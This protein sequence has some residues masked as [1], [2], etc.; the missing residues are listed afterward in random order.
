HG[1]EQPLEERLSDGPTLAC[2]RET[3]REQEKGDAELLRVDRCRHGDGAGDVTVDDHGHA[4]RLHPVNERVEPPRQTAPPSPTR[5]GAGGARTAPHCRRPS[6]PRAPRWTR[7][8][9]Q[10]PSRRARC[11]R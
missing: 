10:P 2:E 1:L 5:E 7:P 6:P 11:R 4:E 3:A 9:R 8:N